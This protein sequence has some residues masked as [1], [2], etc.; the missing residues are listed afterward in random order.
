MTCWRS[1]RTG[2]DLHQPLA[3]SQLPP[4]HWPEQ[5]DDPTLADAILGRL[6]HRYIA[7]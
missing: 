4:D 5:I 7:T 1:S 6:A 3:T 2:K